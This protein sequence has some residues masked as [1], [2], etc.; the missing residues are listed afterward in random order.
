MTGARRGCLR[1]TEFVSGGLGSMPIYEYRCE[2]CGEPFEKLVKMS[3][4]DAEVECP[5]C[6]SKNTRKALSLFG[7]GRRQGEWLPEFGQFV[8]QLGFHL[9]GEALGSRVLRSRMTCGWVTRCCLHTCVHH[10]FLLDAGGLVL[11]G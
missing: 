3:A 8:C 2:N 1:V 4:S 6:G 11:D 7:R 9:R 5:V 10:S